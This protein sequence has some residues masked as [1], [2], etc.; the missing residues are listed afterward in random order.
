MQ[1]VFGIFLHSTNTPEKVIQ[2]LAH[3][4]IS[5]SPSAIH[6]AIHA[7]SIETYETLQEMG[8]THMHTTTLTLTSKQ[9]CQQLKRLMTL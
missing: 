3:M 1:S 5:I 9:S 4:G 7:L 2:V 8:Q 6:S